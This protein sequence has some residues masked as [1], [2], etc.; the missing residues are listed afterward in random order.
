[1]ATPNTSRASTAAAQADGQRA[2]A[3]EL[4]RIAA[5]FLQQNQILNQQNQIL[6]AVSQ[7]LLR[8]EMK[9]RAR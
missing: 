9:A 2:V 8:I 4:Q 7:T 1:M 3:M 5:L 6:N